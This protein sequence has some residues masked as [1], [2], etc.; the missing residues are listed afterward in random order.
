M[1]T[2]QNQVVICP[3]G[4]ITG[5]TIVNYSVKE[6]RRIDLTMGVGYDDDLKKAKETIN[7]VL[8]PTSVS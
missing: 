7:N 5:G 2:P 1:R 3:N 8:I 4:Q 6:T